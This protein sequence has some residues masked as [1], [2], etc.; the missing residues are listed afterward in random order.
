[1][2]NMTIITYMNPLFIIMVILMM[3]FIIHIFTTANPKNCITL[4]FINTNRRHMPTLIGP[5]CIIATNTKSRLLTGGA[6][7]GGEKWIIRLI[8]LYIPENKLYKMYETMSL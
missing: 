1:M 5:I 7:L 2:I 3:I 8:W 4:I 6:P